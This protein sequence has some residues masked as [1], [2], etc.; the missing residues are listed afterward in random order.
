MTRGCGRGAALVSDLGSGAA[1]GAGG[2]GNCCSRGAGGMMI[3][4][5]GDGDGVP[6]S[7]GGTGGGDCALATATIAALTDA[8][9]MA[10]SIECALLIQ[11]PP[12]A[13][14]GEPLPR[15]RR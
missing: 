14:G 7:P 12:P 13:R 5:D 1:R 11:L 15:P 9:R 10:F 4:G 6:I 2:G 3:C 8:V